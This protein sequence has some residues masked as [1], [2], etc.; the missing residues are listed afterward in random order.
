MEQQQLKPFDL[1]RLFVGQSAALV[2]QRNCG[3]S[4]A[5]AATVS[6]IVG[7]H[8]AVI[9]SAAQAGMLR[10]RAAEKPAALSLLR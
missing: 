1:Y 3:R 2:R 7:L 10:I 5:L 8:S 9:S 6:G 4:S